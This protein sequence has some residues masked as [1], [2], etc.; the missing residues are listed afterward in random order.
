VICLGWGKVQLS[1][2]LVE[3]DEFAMRLARRVLEQLGVHAVT[4]AYNGVD[5]L[6]ILRSR[7]MEFDL[8]ISDI[9]MPEM[10]GIELLREIRLLAPNQ[11][12]LMLTGDATEATILTAQEFR[13]DGYLIKPFSPGQLD[14]KITAILAR[15]DPARFSGW[16]NSG[17][18]RQFQSSGHADLMRLYA[19]WDNRRGARSIPSLTD[20]Q[21][22][23][24]GEVADLMPQMLLVGIEANPMRIRYEMVGAKLSGAIGRDLVGKYVDEQPFWFRRFAEPAYRAVIRSRGPHF[25]FVRTIGNF[26]IIKFQ[27]LLLPLA[28]Q[29]QLIDWVLGGI[30]R[31]E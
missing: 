17:E 15:H 19:Y 5:A 23:D 22:L 6:D 9:W 4:T 1:V 10:N 24:G 31:V 25:R 13:V 21:P 28:S 26:S 2:L 11:P 3:D 7:S 29:N 20:L 12:F 14:H 16:Q 8:V 27:R 30:V 18:Q